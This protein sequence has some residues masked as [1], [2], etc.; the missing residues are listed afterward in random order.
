VLGS[1]LDNIMKGDK[2]SHYKF[3]PETLQNYAL[4]NRLQNEGIEKTIRINFDYPPEK[5]A[6]FI[7]RSNPLV[8][9]LA[10]YM[11]ET[12]MEQNQNEGLNAKLAARCGVYESSEVN[13]VTSVFLVRLR[14]K[15]EMTRKGI[16]KSTLAEEALLLGFEGRKNIAELSREKLDHLL[17][18]N[19]AGNISES[20]IKRELEIS[21]DWWKQN[22]EI[23]EK[24]AK[25]RSD[26]LHADHRRVRKAAHDKGAYT[27][28]PGFPVDLIGLYVLLPQGL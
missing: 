22:S 20:V 15:I 1:P 21:L 19:P 12:A 3:N 17:G 14:H 18:K 10:D 6:V 8:S 26:A 16:I 11:L 2:V 24:I 9:V 28:T 25:D 5:N 4:K 23:F 27:V 13:V 7:H